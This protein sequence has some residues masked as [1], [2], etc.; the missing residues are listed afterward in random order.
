MLHFLLRNKSN[1][2]LSKNNRASIKHYF[3]HSQENPFEYFIRGKTIPLNEGEDLSIEECFFKRKKMF[4]EKLME[5]GR[6][7]VVYCEYDAE[8]LFQIICELKVKKENLGLICIDYI[9][10]LNDK[11]KNS[12]FFSRQEELKGICL[13][14]KNCAIE[15]GLPFVVAAQFNREVQSIGQMHPTK[16]GEAGDIERIANLII[17][18]FDIKEEG[19]LHIEILKGREIGSGHTTKL[20][21]NGNTGKIEVA[22]FEGLDK[23]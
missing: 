12:T 2:E 17:G 15:T 10:L 13:K 3:K 22:P 21:Y 1:E 6:L 19:K 20:G 23:L 8:K 9:Q 11:S 4:F 16:I 5:S 14:M 7:N 18:I